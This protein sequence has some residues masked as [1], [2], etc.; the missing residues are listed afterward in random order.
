MIKS[1]MRILVLQIF[2]LLGFA[3]NAQ[4]VK[5]LFDAT[6]AET[7]NN[8]DWIIDAD[9]HNLGWNPNASLNGGTESNAQQ[10]PLPAQSNIISGTVETFWSGALSSWGIDCVKRGYAVETLPYNGSITYNNSSNTQDLSRYKIFVVC[11]PNIRFTT[12]E[13]S[14]ILAFVQNGGSLYMISD[15]T[16]SDRNNDGWD[17]PA[18]WNDLLAGSGMGITFNLTNI[19]ETST[20]VNAIST[21]S[22]IHGPFGDVSKIQWFNGCDITVDPSINPS[23]KIAVYRNGITNNNSKAMAVYARYGKGKV[24]AIGDSSPFDDGSGDSGDQLYNGYFI[25]AS[26]NHQLLI[27]NTTIWLAIRDSIVAPAP[28]VPKAP[29]NLSLQK[30][31]QKNIQLNWVDSSNDEKGFKIYRGNTVGGAYIMIDSTP[32]NIN[33]YLDSNLVSNNYCFKVLAFNNVG[34]SAFSNEACATIDGISTF[35]NCSSIQILPNPSSN[36]IILLGIDDASQV[37][38]INALGEKQK[39]I[40]VSD[41]HHYDISR[42]VPGIY[43]IVISQKDQRD[44]VRRLVIQ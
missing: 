39:L 19:S 24:A 22:L 9:A 35:V 15:H 34:N 42:Y 32:N 6:K 28:T 23:V 33:Y 36:E 21:D 38:L 29:V 18:I 2:L 27:M 41:T 25:D 40:A 14:A 3:L 10:I 26:G 5:I 44:Q 20:S 17:S 16:Q 31:T 11:E 4:Q 30:V 8:A 37:F 7:A 13:K 1:G 43:Q 12:S